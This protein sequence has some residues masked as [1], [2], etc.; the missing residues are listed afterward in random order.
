VQSGAMVGAGQAGG[1]K[2]GHKRSE[3]DDQAA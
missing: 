1:Q 2:H 3:R